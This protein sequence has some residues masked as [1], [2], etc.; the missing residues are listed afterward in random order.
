MDVIKIPPWWGGN[1]SAP[2]PNTVSGSAR[3]D[4]RTRKDLLAQRK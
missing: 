3:I 1:D 2:R 4:P